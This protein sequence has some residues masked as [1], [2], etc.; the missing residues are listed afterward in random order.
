MQEL[1]MSRRSFVK[2][3]TVAG[4]SAAL[5]T[6]LVG[7]GDT[8]VETGDTTPVEDEVKRI[9]TCCRGC[10]KCECGVWVTVV[11]GRAV[12]VE[13]D[14]SAYATQ[15]NA[16]IKAQA[17]MQAAYHPDRLRYPMKRTNPKGDRDPGWVRISW[18]EAFEM[19]HENLGGIVDKY[20]TSA[21]CRKSG[22]SRIWGN[23]GG[24]TKN[25]WPNTESPY[26]GGV[27]VCKGPRFTVGR[28]TIEDSAHYMAVNDYTDVYVQWGTDQTQS[29]YDQA[30]RIVSDVARRA[31]T[32][33]SVDPRRSNNGIEADIHLPLRPGTDNAMALGW[34][35][36][37][38]ERGLYSEDVCRWWTNFP[39]LV[40]DEIEPS[41]WTGVKYNRSKKFEVKTRLLK[42]TDCDPDFLPWDVEGEGDPKR[43]I[44]FD[45]AA[46]KLTYFDANEEGEHA[47]MWETQTE[48]EIPTDGWEFG[49]GG[50]V[51]N[52][53]DM[54]KFCTPALWCDKG[55]EIKLKDGR[56]VTCKTVWQKYWDDCV[57]PMTLERVAEITTCDAED[58][59]KACLLWATQTEDHP[60]GR[61]IDYA[62]GPEQEGNCFQNFRSLMVLI[63]MCDGWDVPGGARGSTRNGIDNF[64]SSGGGSPWEPDP[65]SMLE[66]YDGQPGMDKFPLLRWIGTVF[67]DATSHYEAMI[68]GDPIPIKAFLEFASGINQQANS[69][70]CYEAYQNL[71]FHYSY[72]LWHTVG[73]GLADLLLPA[74]HWMEIP[75]NPRK[76][77]NATGN[78]GLSCNCIKPIG[79]VKFDVE[80]TIG[81]YKAFGVPWYSTED[82]G[83]AW[84]RPIEH[85]LDRAVKSTGMTWA[86]L[87][88]KFQREGWM[89]GKVL[90]PKQWGTYR[91]Y[92]VAE[93]RTFEEEKVNATD[94]PG[95][96]QPTMKMEPWSTVCESVGAGEYALPF[97]MEPPISPI[98][99]PELLEEYPYILTTGARAGVVMYF[100][101]EHR[102]LPWCR[103]LGCVP[104]IYMNSVDAEACGV[105]HGD[106]AWVE[107]KDGKIRLMV[108]VR[109]D[110]KPGV[111]NAD[112]HWWFPEFTDQ[113]DR[114][115]HLSTVNCL[116]DRFAQD[117][118]VGSTE[119]R[120]YLVKVY[121]ATPENSPF[122]NPVPC[123][124]DGVEII[125]TPDDP[126]LK[127]WK[128]QIDEIA[129]DNSKW[130]VYAK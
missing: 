123:N 124:D 104:H 80:I 18:D 48:Y 102:Q 108:D 41:G 21:Y 14:E 109:D 114:G 72:D 22:T 62:L 77:Q 100:H 12:K 57:N 33:I 96:I 106:W 95:F 42:E 4:A 1:S 39:Y 6:G 65:R 128:S 9:R 92:L 91:R 10:G 5:A 46:G 119:I 16:C 130:E 44:V 8:L 29:N 94:I 13:G 28:V 61:A 115:Y 49:R 66:I 81:I 51:P 111:M 122:N 17:S 63:L 97:Y 67:G 103:E 37:V 60:Y 98:S 70:R 2:A 99:T 86:E 116:V 31:K 47:G 11:N 58:I 7:C 40:C 45:E 126:R 54:T 75:G 35:R 34:T 74:E 55:Y 78:I 85:Q 125:H 120:G 129:A 20:G 23:H 110:L 50:W 121:K 87:Y 73:N 68:T 113:A 112:H 36:I 64:M 79:D 84:D 19:V 101:S 107:S 30:G 3:A 15:G 27:Q 76:S 53:P 52:F 105:K 38:M 127:E 43:F 59:E 117:P 56:T 90:E 32:F 93:D 89:D 88:D 71:E 24:S 118:V 82:G 25:L 83:D 26:I 69:N